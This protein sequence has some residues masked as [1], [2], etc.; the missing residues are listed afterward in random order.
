MIT[1][2]ILMNPAHIRILKSLIAVW[3]I[4]YQTAIRLLDSACSFTRQLL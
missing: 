3:Q 4:I 1:P 2:Y